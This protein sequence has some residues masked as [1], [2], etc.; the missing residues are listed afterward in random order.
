MVALRLTYSYT[1]TCIFAVGAA[2]KQCSWDVEHA[3]STLSKEGLPLV[4]G[5]GLTFSRTPWRFTVD[6]D[7]TD[8]TLSELYH[9]T[10]GE[11]GS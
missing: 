3:G 7:C 6:A 1:A 9:T 10:L 4:E 8:L 5:K 2:G 11:D